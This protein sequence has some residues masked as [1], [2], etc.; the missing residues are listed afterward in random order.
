MRSVSVFIII[1]L[2]LCQI[3]VGS[4]GQSITGI[5][6]T[7]NWSINVKN[8]CNRKLKIHIRYYDG[9][10]KHAVSNNVHKKQRI[11][12]STDKRVAVSL[13]AAQDINGNDVF[14]RK[15]LDN[16]RNYIR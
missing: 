5:S 15:C 9:T 16:T 11:G 12:I 6:D 13:V 1:A 4:V 14:E 7:E 8:T 3:L 10:L 2:I